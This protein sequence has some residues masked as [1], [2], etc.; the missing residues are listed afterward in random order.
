[1]AGGTIVNGLNPVLGGTAGNDAAFFGNVPQITGWVGDGTTTGGY[2]RNTIGNEDRTDIANNLANGFFN[3]LLVP[4]DVQN[5]SVSLV[6]GTF[7]IEG[8][9]ELETG[10]RTNFGGNTY[11]Q[12][13]N[14]FIFIGD[15]YGTQTNIASAHTNASL[16]SGR[17]DYIAAVAKKGQV[18]TTG[19][20]S[21]PAL[22]ISTTDN[23]KPYVGMEGVYKTTMI[24]RLPNTNAYRVLLD[25]RTEVIYDGN[26][27]PG[28]GMDDL[29]PSA[30]DRYESIAYKTFY[31]V[32]GNLNDA[33][34]TE[35]NLASRANRNHILVSWEFVADIKRSR[36]AYYS[37]TANNTNSW[38]EASTGA[39][40]LNRN[41]GFIS[42]PYGGVSYRYNGF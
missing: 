34:S 42:I 14:N 32:G 11:T 23:A 25:G 18:T 24:Y 20:Y 9:T 4:N 10:L 13:A 12:G 3:K 7:L 27:I 5:G 36:P 29:N 41:G 2:T 8:M 31:R 38:G 26:P 6:N 30:T 33:P 39:A 28:F 35:T 37:G 16:Y 1:V 15:A 22:D 40:P 19:N 17:R 21:G